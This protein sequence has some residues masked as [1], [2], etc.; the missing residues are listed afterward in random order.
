[1]T[2]ILSPA[3]LLLG[4][5]IWYIRR[6][7]QYRIALLEAQHAVLKRIAAGAP[8]KQ[9]LERICRFVEE[10][11]APGVCS[12]LLLDAERQRIS[13]CAAPSLP[14][15]YISAIDGLKIGPAAG[16]CGT[17]MWRREPVIVMDIA[18]DP[19]WAA[20]RDTALQYGLR[21][22]WS[23]P[24]LTGSGAVLGSFAVYYREVR[25][26]TRR[27]HEIIDV[28]TEL[29]AVAI[30]RAQSDEQLSTSRTRLELALRIAKLGIWE[31]D[32]RN[33]RGFWSPE[34][35]AMFGF[36]ADETPTKEVAMAR[37]LEEDRE[38]VMN[39]HRQ[40]IEQG[41]TVEFQ[42]RVRRVDG[43]I[44][45]LHERCTG[46][47][48]PDGALLS[49][50]GVVQDETQ[51]HQAAANLAAL[52]HAAHEVNT[53]HSLAE[54]LRF[55]ADIARELAGAQLSAIAVKTRSQENLEHAFSKS[56]KYA[57]LAIDEAAFLDRLHES[58]AAAPRLRHTARAAVSGFEAFAASLQHSGAL[59]VPL[60]AR[61]G[62]YLGSIGLW[63]KED[64]EFGEMDERLQMQLADIAAVG[65]ENAQLYASLEARVSE[66]TRELELSNR[67]L[68]SFSYSV[69]HDLRGPLRAMAGFS[70]LLQEEHAAQLDD[71]AKHYL[72][73]INAAAGRMGS[74]IDDLLELARMSHVDIERKQI[75]VSQLTAA[76]AARMPERFLGRQVELHIQP[77]IFVW[78][79]PRL[80]EVALDNMLDN[81][82]KFTRE[83]SPAQIRVGKQEVN[84][85]QQVFIK[86]NGVG[87]DTRYASNLFGVFQRLHSLNEF[88]GTGVGLATVQRIVQR[89]GGCV[90][91]DARI[92]E[93]ATIYF[94]L[95]EIA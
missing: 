48:A 21:A 33:G 76:I 90:W 35:R 43:S 56:Y 79:D 3:L 44:R 52:A 9:S 17:A 4:F 57:E 67:E 49:L 60:V 81:A 37:V 50:A 8:L 34:F 22:C 71:Q 18:S 27:S 54:L 88:P 66:R 77:G 51:Q 73:R 36:S 93:G 46:A 92:G 20:Y 64:G 70:T 65:V 94:T 31:R 23:K 85:E 89:H 91:A 19:P 47:L 55:I 75:D 16:S 10:L 72:Q 6:Q 38:Y 68:E 40:A 26:P 13:T 80:F 53:Q 87:F 62:D 86:D 69:S 82:W 15:A 63:D 7:R 28:A 61:N 11:D 1:M 78:A 32:F 29:A 24:I 12:V 58:N 14:E 39:S 25:R 45:Y 41:K 59:V 83:R 5:G 42:Y 30:E 84:G 74:L 95:P 2:L